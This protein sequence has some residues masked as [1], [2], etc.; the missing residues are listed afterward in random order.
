VAAGEVPREVIGR[1]VDVEGSVASAALRSGRTQRLEEEP[2]RV[3]FER[4]GLGRFGVD[5]RAGLVVPLR[6]RG[7]SYGV[8][9]ALDRLVDGSVFSHDDQRLLEAFASSAATAIATADAAASERRSQRL[10]AAEEERRRWARELHDE[11]LQGLAAVRLGLA[12]ALRKAPGDDPLADSLRDALAQLDAEVAGLRSLITELRPASLDELGLEAAVEGL[13]E[14][15]GAA[16]LDVDLHVDLAFEQ[17]REPARPVAELET[18]AY[19]LVQEALTN[20]RKHG[21][22]TRAVVEI[23]EARDSLTVSVRDNGDGF[24]PAAGTDG[25]GLL[26]MRERVTLLDGTL[27]VVSAPGEGTAISATF[28]VTGRRPVAGNGS[29]LAVRQA[30]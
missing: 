27:E 23:V 16:G 28:P 14:R 3:R 22:A 15:V 11:T 10:A 20:A 1:R 6:F 5:A 9:M 17:G 2:N 24:D 7:Q 30:G 13:V 21:R 18:A 29:P 12:V 25:F 26:G 8:M 4:H 19:R